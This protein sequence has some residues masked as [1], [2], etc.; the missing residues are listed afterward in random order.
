MD[1]GSGLDTGKRLR[2]KEAC[3]ARKSAADAHGG[4]LLDQRDLA[5]A[6]R[7]MF[8]EVHADGQIWTQIGAIGHPGIGRSLVVA[9]ASYFGLPF[10]WILWTVAS[11]GD[12]SCRKWARARKASLAAGGLL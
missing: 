2:G 8:S 1:G 6:Q 3:R 9:D 11:S 5:G 12:R 4:G 7:A 10:I